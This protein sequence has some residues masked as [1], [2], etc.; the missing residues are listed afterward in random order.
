MFLAD[1]PD[2]P[3]AK[4]AMSLVSAASDT[5]LL[6]HVWRTWHFGHHLI[7]ERLADADLEVAFVAAMLHDLG[8]TQRFDS[9]EP[10]ERASAMAATD[11]L[12]ELGWP[13]DRVQLAATAIH[14]HLDLASAQ[15]RP[16]IALV[17]LGAAADVVGLRVDQL[18]GELIDAVL[19]QHP[20]RGFAEILVGIL[21]GQ[22]QRKPQSAIALLF[23]DLLLHDIAFDDLVRACPLDQR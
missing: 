9:D 16:E 21:H 22:V 14:D 5:A 3:A 8:L 11:L 23:H 10:F 18:P 15:A 13:E 12:T 6:D 4:A 20:R 7:A 2:T 17:H 1:P 19:A